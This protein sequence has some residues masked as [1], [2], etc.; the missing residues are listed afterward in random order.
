MKFRVEKKIGNNVLWMETGELAKQAQGS[1]LI[2]YGDTVV[3]CAVC[4]APCKPGTDFFPLTCDYRERPAAAGKFPGGYIK[5]EGRP[6]LKEVLTS[7]LID[8]PLRPLFPKGFFNE[9][10]VSALVLA[11]D[12]QVDPD[13][14]SMIGSATAVQLAG[15]PID[16]PLASVRIGLVNDE[17]IPFP[18]A[19][20]LENSELDLVISG[21]HDSVL[22][23]EGFARELPEPKMYEAILEAQKFVSEICALQDELVQKVNPQR[24]VYT[25]PETGPM[26]QKIMAAYYKD[27]HAA[28]KTSGKLA[29]AEACDAVKAA[30]KEALVQELDASVE[31]GK[32]NVFSA[33]YFELAWQEFEERV[34][35]DIILS[36]ERLDGRGVKEVRPIECRVNVIPRVHGSAVFQ[37]G[38]TQAL[39]TVTLGTAKDEQRVE[40]LSGEYM[41]KFMLDYN[42]PS[43]S[44]GECRPNRGTGRREYGH[45]AL[46]ERSVKPVIP[47]PEE[48]PY[49]VRIISDIL[50]SNG[51]SSMATVCGATLGLMSAGVPISNPV[52]GIS[53]GLVKEEDGRW[54]TITDIMGD[55]DHFGDMDFK[56]AGTQIGVTGIQLDLKTNGISKEIILQTLKQAREAR[57][58]ILRKMISAVPRPA[59]D[60]SS[61]APRMFRT[62][63]DPD[64]IGLLIGPGGKTIRAIQDST[65]ASIDI[66]NDGTVSIASAD[67]AGAKAALN[68]VERLTATVEIGRIYDGTVTSIQNFGAF[69]EIL[70]GRDGLCHISEL[71]DNYVDDIRSFCKI[72]DKFRVKVIAVDDQNRIKLSRKAVIKEEESAQPEGEEA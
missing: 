17:Y 42:F 47:D 59:E 22:M 62:K 9:V 49:T 3:I 55:E 28:K 70:P 25:P 37:R 18:T 31:E 27:F 61:F 68:E 14:I 69:I 36:G 11:S 52:A 41:K 71:S 32:A 53:V 45:G 63:I 23:I 5:R 29:R 40:G 57:I 30:A 51:S 19:E 2:G 1:V 43:F 65:G 46:A 33:E 58:G 13:V 6:G 39:I 12:Q 50:E 44:V 7:R 24:I 16:G 21:N 66:D 64:K 4:T 60:I 10:Q 38:E 34:V 20:N 15:L 8:R 48:F 67:E 26:F 72:G 54:I 56:V 35:R